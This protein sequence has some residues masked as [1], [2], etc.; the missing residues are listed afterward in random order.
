MH[1]AFLAAVLLASSAQ[2][3]IR[4][5]MTNADGEVVVVQQT[6][7]A[8][9]DP[10]TTTINTLPG[11]GG[12]GVTTGTGTTTGLGGVTTSTTNWATFTGTGT[13]TTSRTTAIPTLDEDETTLPTTTP[14]TTRRPGGQNGGQG[15]QPQGVVGP[16][17]T[18][19]P[20]MTATT[21]WSDDVP[22]T[23][24]NSCVSPEAATVQVP[25]GTRQG[26]SAYLASVGAAQS[27]LMAT[28]NASGAKSDAVSLISS[29]GLAGWMAMFVGMITAGYGV[30]LM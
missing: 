20:P 10:L 7:D 3:Q 6:T 13:G 25:E 30:Y 22:Y 15:Q 16:P 12:A 11:G 27:S 29:G 2:A 28:Y 24:R 9:G 21:Y 18:T 8:D 19:Y 23:W 1:A 14:T 5:T 4:Q 17:T 26:A